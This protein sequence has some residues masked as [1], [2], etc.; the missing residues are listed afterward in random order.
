MTKLLKMK[1]LQ[2]NF[3]SVYRNFQYHTLF[4]I[5]EL[6]KYEVEIDLSN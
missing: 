4:C 5:N 2:K 6:R 1:N 3:N